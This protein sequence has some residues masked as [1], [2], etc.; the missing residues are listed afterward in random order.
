MLKIHSL[1][2]ILFSIVFYV[3]FLHSCSSSV[4]PK[5]RAFRI[6]DEWCECI[7]SHRDEAGRMEE[8]SNKYKEHINA[9]L[10]EIAAEKPIPDSLTIVTMRE[11]SM[12]MT[13]LAND[14]MSRS[15]TV[16]RK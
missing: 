6:L 12:M 16:M 15:D 4:P 5:Q 7:S 10:K 11:I 3:P 2:L 9:T 13:K 8:C 1:H 14:C